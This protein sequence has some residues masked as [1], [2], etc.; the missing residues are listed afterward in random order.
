MLHETAPLETASL[1]LAGVTTGA[2]LART[3]C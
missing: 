1:R 3:S 2:Q